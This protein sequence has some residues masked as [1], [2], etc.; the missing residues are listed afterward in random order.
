MFRIVKLLLSMLM[1][2]P[3]KELTRLTACISMLEG[4]AEAHTSF[5]GNTQAE[6]WY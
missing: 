3:S 1:K 4:K 6:K 2:A 5:N